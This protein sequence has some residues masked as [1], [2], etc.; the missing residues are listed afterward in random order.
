MDTIKFVIEDYVVEA[1]DARLPVINVYI[2]GRNLIDLV[3]Q[4]E[5]QLP[6]GESKRNI[7]W[8]YIGYEVSRF[9]IFQKEMLGKKTYPR[10]I[11]LTCTCTIPQCNCIMADII[12]D[13]QTITW[14]GL[15][16]PWIGGETPSP[17]VDPADAREAGWQPVDYSGLGP[18]MFD[19]EQYLAALEQVTR[20]CEVYNA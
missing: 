18:Y 9:E 11:V 13:E 12:F 14:S 10:S 16:S 7:D 20:A 6:D 8:P 15:K 5:E 2:N 3:S 4:I 19:R 1:F 17:W